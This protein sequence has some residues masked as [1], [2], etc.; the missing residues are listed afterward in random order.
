MPEKKNPII[1][2][3]SDPI[4]EVKKTLEKAADLTALQVKFHYLSARR[5][6]AYAHLGELTYALHHPRKDTTPEEID[7]EIEQTMQQI[8]SL[9]HK[10]T[11]LALRIKF[12]KLDL[13]D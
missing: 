2:M 1:K 5:K 8:T 7:T 10:I 3:E 12:L 9:S 11:D 6:D 13:M 4:E